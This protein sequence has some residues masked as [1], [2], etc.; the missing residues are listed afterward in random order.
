MKYPFMR[1]INDGIFDKRET[2]NF[3]DLQLLD[4]RNLPPQNIL[5]MK[6][7]PNS[8]SQIFFRT[9]IVLSNTC[10]INVVNHNCI[11]NDSTAE[12]T[13]IF[14]PMANMF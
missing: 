2:E 13:P 14:N 6:P 7:F 8:N 1:K 5:H 10:V 4:E 12:K 3:S 11:R 9:W